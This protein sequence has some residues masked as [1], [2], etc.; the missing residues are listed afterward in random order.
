M[1]SVSHHE[2][3]HPNSTDVV[4]TDTNQPYLM[5]LGFSKPLIP[6]VWLE[7]PLAGVIG[8]PYFGLCSDQCRTRWGRRRTFILGGALA[9]TLSFPALAWA[10]ELVHT[11][12]WVLGGRQ[13]RHALQTITMAAAAVLIWV[14]NF[15]IQPLQCGPRALIVE[16]CPPGQVDAANA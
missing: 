8:Q 1:G 9:I 13:D 11:A 7:G 2:P 15:A 10:G 12:A 3:S 14:L 4:L 16:A 5:S 6:F